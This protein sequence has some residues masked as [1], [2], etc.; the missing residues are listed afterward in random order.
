MTGVQSAK[1]FINFRVNVNKFNNRHILIHSLIN[2]LDDVIK[3]VQ[4]IQF[5]QYFLLVVIDLLSQ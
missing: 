2:V 3:Y 1:K 5:Q 4:H